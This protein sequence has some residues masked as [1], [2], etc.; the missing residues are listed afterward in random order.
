MEVK[1]NYSRNLKNFYLDPNNYRFADHKDYKKVDENDLLD[2]KVQQT[3]AART[4]KA[5][6]LNLQ[7]TKQQDVFL[8]AAGPVLERLMREAGAAVIL[9]RRSVYISLNAIDITG[10]AISLLDETLGSGEAPSEP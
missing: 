2:E 6:A 3:R 7:L 4:A 1:T 10:D 8:K 9:E 5:R